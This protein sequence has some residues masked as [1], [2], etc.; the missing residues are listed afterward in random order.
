LVETSTGTV[1]NGDAGEDGIVITRDVLIHLDIELG[2]K[3]LWGKGNKP[4]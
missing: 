4:Q 2:N 3:V 1:V